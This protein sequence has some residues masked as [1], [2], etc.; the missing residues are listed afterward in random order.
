MGAGPGD[1]KSNAVAQKSANTASSKVISFHNVKQVG[2]L[3]A[4]GNGF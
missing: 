1:P 4:G 2:Y 3:V